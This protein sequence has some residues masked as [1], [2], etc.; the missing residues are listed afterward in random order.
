MII[1]DGSN[2]AVLTTNKTRSIG[3]QIIEQV[4]DSFQL[5]YYF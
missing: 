5:K 2:N 3:Q 1:H 4:L